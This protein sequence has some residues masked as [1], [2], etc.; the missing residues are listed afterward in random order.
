[1]AMFPAVAAILAASIVCQ[2]IAAILAVRLVRITGLR[3]AWTAI[4]FAIFLMAVRRTISFLDLIAAGQATSG[5][6]WPELVALLISALMAVGL[7]RISPYFTSIQNVRDHFETQVNKRTE[8]LREAKE[9]AE[10][11][12]NEAEEANRAKNDFLSRMSHDLRTPLNAILGFA[13]LLELDDHKTLSREQRENTHEILRAGEHLLEMVNE[14]LNLSQIESGRLNLYV[15][16]VELKPALK[17]SLI[18][19]EPLATHHGVNLTTDADIAGITGAYAVRADRTR[20]KQVLVNLLS[21]AIKYNRPGGTVG[22]ACVP[23]NSGQVCISVSDTG[24][25]IPQD[26][27][28]EYS[29]PSIAWVRNPAMWKAPA[30]AWLSPASWWS[31]WVAGLAWRAPRGRAADSTSPCHGARQR[32]RPTPPRPPIRWFPSIRR[33]P[34][35]TK[36]QT[37][38]LYSMWRTIPPTWIW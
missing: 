36:S 10:T 15:E 31:Q 26:R 2:V 37:A 33:R 3:F 19:V 29:P 20:L 18:L 11:A 14:V 27:Q 12:K 5:Q 24:P 16:S 34:I 32:Y 8:D 28:K 23:D 21:N 35:P 17:E 9:A 22:L 25:G 4:A 7:A 1:M 13:Q 6:L 30:S 38:A